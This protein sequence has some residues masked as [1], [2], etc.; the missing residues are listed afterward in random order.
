MPSLSEHVAAL[1]GAKKSDGLAMGKGGVACVELEAM[2]LGQGRLRWLI[3]Q[4]QL[5]VIAS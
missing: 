5:A 4:K 3:R 2:R 1:I